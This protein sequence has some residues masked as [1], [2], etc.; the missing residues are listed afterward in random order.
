MTLL[1]CVKTRYVI[2]LLTTLALTLVIS[3]SLAFNFTVICMDNDMAVAE[4]NP[5]ATGT[6]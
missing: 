3:N 6:L 5:N 1:Y 4:N 2:L